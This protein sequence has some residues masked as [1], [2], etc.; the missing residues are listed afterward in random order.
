MYVPNG[1]SIESQQPQQ[2][3]QQQQ[4][5]NIYNIDFVTKFR[6][7]DLAWIIDVKHQFV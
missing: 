2:Q 3:Q 7:T 5:K 4:T 6:A 1:D